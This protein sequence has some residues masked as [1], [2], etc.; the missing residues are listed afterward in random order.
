MNYKSALPT[1]KPKLGIRTPVDKRSIDHSKMNIS[2]IHEEDNESNLSG[3][4]DHLKLS[5]SPLNASDGFP[6]KK[7]S[8]C[9]SEV[10]LVSLSDMLTLLET[11]IGYKCD[12]AFLEESALKLLRQ[13]FKKHQCS[14]HFYQYIMVDLDDPTILLNRFMS[15]VNIILSENKVSIPVVGFSQRDTEKI[16]NSCSTNHVE[17][18]KKP[19][20]VDSIKHLIK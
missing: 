4:P 19:A 7:K 1:E 6:L 13:N 14:C 9:C 12:E 11:K 8:T 18:I 10:L 3:R 15:S 17:Y 5:T 2:Q 16:R 20:T